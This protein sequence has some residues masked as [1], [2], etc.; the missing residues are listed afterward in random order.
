MIVVGFTG[1]A[2]AGKT[3]CARLLMKHI[4]YS[5]IHSFAEPLKECLED[6]FGF[7][8]DQLY[9]KSKDIVDERYGVTP[10]LVMQR[11][12]TEFVRTTVPN[13]W[14][15]LM[16]KQ[17]RYSSDKCFIVDDIRFQTEYNLIAKY[18]T[19]F[20][21]RRPEIV[22]SDHQSERGVKHD[23]YVI[24]NDKGLKELED[25]IVTICNLL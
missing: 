4:L 18:G 19:V 11:F 22:G 21:V 3:T 7:S 9:G 25:Q 23:G 16:D 1:F 8:S 24:N 20:E 14:E 5:G 6:L 17:I 12:G 2:Q 13:L 15:I 10:R